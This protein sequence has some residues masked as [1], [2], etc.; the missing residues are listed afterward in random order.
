[1]PYFFFVE[2]LGPLIELIGYIILIISIFTGSIYLE[3]AI[4]FFLLS[5]IYGSIYSMASVLLEEWSMERYPKVK[6]FVILFLVSMTETLWYRPLTV[7][8]RVEG[9]IEM[10]IGKKGWGEMV[11]KGVSND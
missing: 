1:M 11:R 3:F 8:W 5:L 6:H 2:F 7:I 4:I 9:M 10:L